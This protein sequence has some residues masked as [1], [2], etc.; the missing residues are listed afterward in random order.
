MVLPQ[1]TIGRGSRIRRCI[2]DRG[3]VLPENTIVGE[4][5]EEDARRFHRS[6][7]GVVLITKD[8]LAKL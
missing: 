3:C 4:N 2:I 6:E 7:T 1:V 5:A 8:M